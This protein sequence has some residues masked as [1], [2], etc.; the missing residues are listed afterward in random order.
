MRGRERSILL[1]TKSCQFEDGQEQIKKK[2]YWYMLTLFFLYPATALSFKNSK[3]VFL[4]ISTPFMK[5]N[6]SNKHPQEVFL[7]ICILANCLPSPHYL[8]T[9]CYFLSLSEKVISE[10]I[11]SDY[12]TPGHTGLDRNSSSAPHQSCV[13]AVSFPL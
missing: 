8:K 5:V 3:C 1:H 7:V 10:Q 11:Y 4:K 13:Q 2:N 6:L 9:K 12:G